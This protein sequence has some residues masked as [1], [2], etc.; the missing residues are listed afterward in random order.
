VVK[1]V[2]PNDDSINLHDTNSPELFAEDMRA[3]SSG[4]VRVEKPL[5]LAEL[6][7][8]GKRGW[9]RKEIDQVL[10][11]GETTYVKLP[12]AVPTYLSYW[13]AWVDD[14]GQIHFRD[15]VY[16]EDKLLQQSRDDLEALIL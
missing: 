8:K 11:K 10:A 7:L 1:F 16:Q 6:L 2:I 13:T 12:E 3:L 9:D 14:K 4:C 15:D 5:E